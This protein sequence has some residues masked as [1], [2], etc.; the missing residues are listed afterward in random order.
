MQQSRLQK[1]MELL[2]AYSVTPTPE[3]VDDTALRKK[4]RA[5]EIFTDAERATLLDAL[6]ASTTRHQEPTS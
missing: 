4:V 2:G 6:D 1:T 3:L 5:S